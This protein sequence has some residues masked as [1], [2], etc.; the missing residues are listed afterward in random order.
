MKL[1]HHPELLNLTKELIT[2]PS[3]EDNKP[4]LKEVL[5]IASKDLTEFTVEKFDKNQMPS[6]LI[7]NTDKRPE[8]F[9]VILNAHLDVVPGR[10]DQYIPVEKNGKL[11]GRGSYDM[12]AAGAAE[13]LVF[14][15]VAKKVDYPL[16]LQ[17]V[18]DE[19]ISGDNGVGYQVEQNVLGDFVIAGEP[20]NFD[21]STE[22]KGLIWAKITAFGK[23]AHGSRP[24][25]GDNAIWKMKK[26]LDTLEKE[27]KAMNEEVWET[28]INLAMI[29]TP[30]QTVNKV[31]DECS[32]TLDIR[33]IPQENKQ[34]LK[35]IKQLMP[36]DFKLEILSDAPFQVAKMDSFVEKL[37]ESIHK[38]ADYKPNYISNTWASDV[39][40]YTSIGCNGVN[41]GPQGRG[42]HENEEWVDI[43]SL[44]T[45]YEILK[46]FLLSIK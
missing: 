36:K 39:R 12:K 16:A 37:T 3:T 43:K 28:T 23:P 25:L 35:T 1:I 26:F 5:K 29:E 38:I 31:A 6:L 32:I 20:T 21:I 44:D 22:G 45:Y 33:H 40:Y 15:E 18:T 4:A 11:Y 10:T 2:I 13:I 8:K 34:I 19:E 9:Q 41:F 24:W 30:N 14:K 46:D 42:M 17:L 7:Y 27:L